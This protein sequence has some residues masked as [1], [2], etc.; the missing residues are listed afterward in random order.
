MRTLFWLFLPDEALL[1]VMMA[2]G[3]LLMLG[4]RRVAGGL[5]ATALLL[6][7][8]SPFVEALMSGLPAWVSLV[9][10]VVLGLTIFRALASLF[11]GRRAAAHMVGI[12]AAD[13]VRFL[14]RCLFWP[15]RVLGRAC[16]AVLI[17]RVS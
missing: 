4:F 12:L 2:A 1:L 17:G 3:L 8:L 14:V 11:L 9:I 15:V 7:L 6:P 13:V 10:L 5:L 16:R